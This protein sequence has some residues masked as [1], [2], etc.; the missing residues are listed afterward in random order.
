MNGIT[1]PPTH[2]SLGSTFNEM[3]NVQEK[4]GNYEKALGYFKQA[5]NICCNCL[6]TNHLDQRC[7]GQL[8][9]HPAP[10]R[11]RLAVLAYAPPPSRRF[12]SCPAT[13]PPRP[14]SFKTNLKDQIL[15]NFSNIYFEIAFR[16]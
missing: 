13:A 4:M 11:H 8:K 16:H 6:T 3:G 2:P 15:A 5:L 9:N 7:T 12:S 1:L 10:S 14:V